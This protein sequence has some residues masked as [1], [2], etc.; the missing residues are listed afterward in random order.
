MASNITINNG[1]ATPVA[2][3][4]TFAMQNGLLF[5][6]Q[7]MSGGTYEGFAKLTITV[8]PASSQNMGHRVSWK[9]D[10]PRLATTAPASGSGVQPNPVAAYTSVAK[11]E[12]MIPKAADLDNRKDLLAFSKNLLAHTVMAS[13]IHDLSTPA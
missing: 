9:I 13:L 6:W 2:K 4:F 3:T 10:V 12:F 1:A 7:E 8:R 11:G 5:A